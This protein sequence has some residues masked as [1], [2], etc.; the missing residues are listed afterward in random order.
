MH[1]A[2]IRHGIVAALAAIAFALAVASGTA[3]AAADPNKVLRVASPDIDTLDPH[4]YTDDP[5][6]MV[7]RAIFE[8]LYEWNYLATPA[9]LAPNTAEGPIEISDGGKTWTVKLKRGIRFTDDPAFRGKPRELT[10]GDYVYSLKRWLDPN[11]RRG[12]APNNTDL[13]VGARAVVDAASKAGGK[14]DYDKPIEGLRALD[15]YT[16]QLKLT[17][18]NYPIIEG[19]LV[20]GAVAREVVDAAGGDIRAHPVG[21]GPYKLRE[22]KRGSRIVLDANPNYRTLQFPESGDPARAP[23]VRSMRGTVLPQVGVVEVSVIE[24]DSTRLLEFERGKLDIAVLRSASASR[25]LAGNALK[26]EYAARGIVRQVFA[27]PFLFSFYFNYADPQLG[28]N[29]T[30]RVALRRAIAMAYDFGN[31]IDVIYA[32]QA[33]IANQMVPPGVAGHDPSMPPRPRPDPAGANALLDKVGYGKRDAQGYR[34]TPEGKPLTLTLSLRSGGSSRE[35]ETQW[36]RDLAAI[37]LR[38]AFHATPFQEVIKEIENGQFQIYFGGFGGEPSGYAELTQLQGKQPGTINVSRYRNAEYDKEMA[39]FL[40][41][42]DEPTQRGASRRM[43][44]IVAAYVPMLPAV[45]RLENDFV[46]PWMQGVSPPIF[47]N[48]WKYLDIDL[49]QRGKAPH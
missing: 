22:W 12:G 17:E 43:S 5:S 10:A 45:F 30:A 34:L 44:E 26:P 47:D 7:L 19:F 14:F 4:Q 13:I 15:R 24:E 41:S 23:L 33:Q 2:A 16:L 11:L 6:F 37:G 35:V 21:T 29:A 46:Q 1:A 48:Y 28:G 27:E 32:G 9:R 8:G 3:A 25:L 42:P 49:A 18:P 40:R 31:M 39:L 38:T 20:L 36:R